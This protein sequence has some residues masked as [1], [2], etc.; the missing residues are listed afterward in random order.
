M[1]W[2]HSRGPSVSLL[3]QCFTTKAGAFF[4][5]LFKKCLGS[6]YVHNTVLGRV[7]PSMNC[8]GH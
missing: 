4:H 5:L 8:V 2:R 7:L 1:G 6:H 3:V